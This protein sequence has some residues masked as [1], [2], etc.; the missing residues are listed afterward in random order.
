MTLSID[1]SPETERTLRDRA[2]AA[3]QDLATFVKEAIAE[4][5]EQEEKEQ[6]SLPASH[7]E[8]RKRLADWIELHPVLDHAV[9]DSRESIYEG[10]GE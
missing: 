8:F 5:L 10:R 2:A 6:P 7:A 1:F 4:K 3:G 9:D